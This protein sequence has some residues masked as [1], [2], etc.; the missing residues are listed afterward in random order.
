MQEF[1]YWANNTKRKDL[2]ERGG[3]GRTPYTFP[4]D[5]PLML[6]LFQS[7]GTRNSH[8]E[9]AKFQ[10]KRKVSFKGKSW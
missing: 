4:L 9:N 7:L 3:R 6:I 1:W 2:M 8:S 5:P 10:L